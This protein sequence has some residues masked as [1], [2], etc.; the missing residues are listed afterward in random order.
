MKFVEKIE[1][2][3]ACITF[4]VAIIPLLPFL[5]PLCIYEIMCYCDRKIDSVFC[6]GAP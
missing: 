5:I 2:I 6:G 4:G 1:Y 3:S